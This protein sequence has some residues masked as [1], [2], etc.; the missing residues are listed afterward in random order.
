[1][2]L[3][4]QTNVMSRCRT[5]GSTLDAALERLCGMRCLTLQPRDLDGQHARGGRGSRAS[6]ATARSLSS[7]SN[8]T[9]FWLPLETGGKVK[10]NHEM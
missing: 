1:M 8:R 10:L 9:A 6:R 3:A 5:V 4:G 7:S 2:K